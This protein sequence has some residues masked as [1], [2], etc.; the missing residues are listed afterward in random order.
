MH[1]EDFP[2]A[3]IRDGFDE[4]I[5]TGIHHI[6]FLYCLINFLIPAITRQR[7][8]FKNINKLNP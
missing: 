7:Y 6:N 5:N 8:N 1:V 4:L 3:E 2:E